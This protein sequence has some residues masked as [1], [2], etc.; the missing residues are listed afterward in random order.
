VIEPLGIAAL[1][2]AA[3]VAGAIDAIAGG[4]GLITVPA[5]L[6]AT[7]DATLALGTNKGQSLF[8]SLSA[9]VAFF[10][11]G[12]IDGKRIAPTF[13]TACVGAFVGVRLVLWIDRNAVRPVVLALLLAVAI[14]FAVRGR[15]KRSAPARVQSDA[16]MERDASTAHD[17]TPAEGKGSRDATSAPSA[18]GARHPL[19]VASAIGFA[20]GAYDGFFGPGTGT[21]LIAAYAAAFGDDLT[22]A[23]ANA[24]VSN[25]ASNLASFATF[26]AAGRVDFRLALPMAAAQI[27][28]GSL[29][30][31]A[32][33][34]GGDRLVRSGV[35]FVTFAIVL[36][37]AWQ[38]A[39]AR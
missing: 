37:L 19:A 10:R 39:S 6:I 17:S 20:L 30:A 3:L 25:F 1:A 31:R 24:K 12:H 18:F 16:E 13:F 23:S 29:G 21:L 26:A 32:A 5:L 9:L 7:P 28:G 34:R 14:L 33:V 22:R 35:V 36:R 4:G 15:S 8:G 11:S 27:I 38:M 2:G